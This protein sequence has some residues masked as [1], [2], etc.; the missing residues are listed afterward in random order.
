M[1]LLSQQTLSSLLSQLEGLA[2]AAAALFQ[3]EA[4]TTKSLT[5]IFGTAC[6]CKRIVDTKA[7]GPP[8]TTTTTP[9][10]M[11]FELKLTQPLQTVAKQLLRRRQ[12]RFLAL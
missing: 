1:H 9:P 10:S 3:P 7:N 11:H 8:P 4:I 12:R 2:I 5:A 6:K